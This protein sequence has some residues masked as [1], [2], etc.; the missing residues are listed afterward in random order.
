MKT[1]NSRTISTRVNLHEFAKALD[2][3]IA[4]GIPATKLRS[5]SAI[6]RTAILI[7]CTLT[8]NPEAPASQESTDII[9]QIWK[10]SSKLS[11]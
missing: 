3:L 10:E 9:K 1:A 5:N 2:G 7:C 4:H 11:I 6:M 8:N